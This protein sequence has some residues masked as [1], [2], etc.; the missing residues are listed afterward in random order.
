MSKASKQL[1]GLLKDPPKRKASGYDTQAVVTRIE[2]G[3]A[4]VHIPGGVSETPVRMTINASVGDTVQVRISDKRAFIVGNATA[5]PTDDAEAIVAKYLAGIA[6]TKATKAQQTA[7]SA[8]NASDENAEAMATAVLAINHDI[9]NLQDQIDGNITSWFYPVDPTM[10]NEPAVNWT[11]EAD[12]ENHL[13]DLYYNTDTGAIWRFTIVGGSYTWQQL[14]DSEIAEALRIAREAQDTADSKRR[15]FYRTPVPPYDRGDLW[16]QGASGDILRCD[17]AKSDTQTYA[18]SDW[19]LASKYTDDS[20][21][22]SFIS[23]TYSDDL[24][25]I[26]SQIDGKAETW[27][28][29]SDPSSGWS[30]A[31]K[32]NHKGDL[33]YRTTDNKTFR[34]TGSAWQEQTVPAEVFDEIDGKSAIFVGTA[35]PSGAEDGDLWFKSANDPILTY[36]GGNWIEYNKYTDDTVANAEVEARTKLIRELDS[37]TLTCYV[38]N[39]VGVFTNASGSVDIVTLTWSLNEPTITGTLASYSS[40][41]IIYSDAISYA[42][43]S[44]NT[45]IHFDPSTGQITLGGNVSFDGESTLSELVGKLSEDHLEAFIEYTGTSVILTAKL[46]KNG[47]DITRSYAASNYKWYYKTADTFEYI[48]SGYTITVPKVT[49]GRAGEVRLFNNK[50]LIDSQ[51]RYITDKSGNKLLAYTEV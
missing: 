28:Q 6:E 33:W 22:T 13:G 19:V 16:V 9:A 31:E 34:Y 26:Q 27:Y 51:G 12:R 48:G 18:E 14:S 3:T 40:S 46:T 45:F 29:T 43:G 21:L 23:G 24:Q 17:T 15:V 20:A 32:P 8:L 39:R 47:E 30:A 10:S 11:T 44:N 25:G 38:G 5:P 41:G 49:F 35:T 50:Y 2:D 36:V 37:G 42:I 4:W 1:V 7:E